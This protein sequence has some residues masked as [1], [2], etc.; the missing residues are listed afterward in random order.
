M[1]SKNGR[2][3]SIGAGEIRGRNGYILFWCLD[4]IE[5]LN[6]DKTKRWTPVFL[7]PLFSPSPQSEQSIVDKYL[8]PH[9]P[10][11][12]DVTETLNLIDPDVCYEDWL[13]CLIALHWYSNQTGCYMKGIAL[14]WSQKG[15]KYKEGE[16]ESKWRS[17]H[18]VSNGTDTAEV[19]TIS[20]LYHLAGM[21]IQ[22]SDK[23]IVPNTLEG[24][25]TSLSLLNISFPYNTRS[26]AREVRSESEDSP[27]H[28]PPDEWVPVTEMLRN[29]LLSLSEE[30]VV[31]VSYKHRVRPI[32]LRRFDAWMDTLCRQLIVDPWKDWLLKLPKWDGEERVE[33]L[34]SHLFGCQDTPYTRWCSLFPF[35][36]T[37]ERTFQP[38]CKLDEF[39]I[40][41]GKQG[42]GKSTFL[43]LSLPD[44]FQETYFTD[45][46]RFGAS[47]QQMV[48]VLQGRVIVEAP[49][50]IMD[51]RKTDNIKA[52]IFAKTDNI[53]LSYRRD[54]EPLPRMCVIVGTSNERAVLPPDND[55]RRFCIIE[56]PQ[57][58]RIEDSILVRDRQQIWAES[59]HL[60]K[61]GARANLPRSL[62]SVR[63]EFAE[64]YRPKDDDLITAIES[65]LL[66]IREE[67]HQKKH[68]QTKTPVLDRPPTLREIVLR[69]NAGREDIKSHYD[70][71]NKRI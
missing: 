27:I 16:V 48:E 17:F 11:V 25:Q 23:P 52:F 4:L 29:E 37:V 38:S 71:T 24:F 9:L 14:E 62:S 5:E 8:A 45:A 40:L 47:D 21:K 57:G 28:V 49:E 70:T 64:V 65:V 35:L 1:D 43:C 67:Y 22:S 26:L 12:A 13:R 56:L 46:L 55:Y 58:T 19:V 41:V 10:S 2:W 7:A 20:T 59:L 33:H 15:T 3:H 31:A 50:M 54:P 18:R 39:P 6:K 69:I 36:G 53:R 63:D 32:H 66:D 44:E 30:Q 51:P 60:Y 68:P 61:S 34:L 42:I